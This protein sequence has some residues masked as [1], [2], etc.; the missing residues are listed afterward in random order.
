MAD[1]LPRSKPLPLH[2]GPVGPGIAV[3]NRCRQVSKDEWPHSWVIT[4]CDVG[5][6]G[7]DE[8]CS[9]TFTHLLSTG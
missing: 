4:P 5:N 9:G 8:Q 3:A 7:I 6:F 1:I 2:T